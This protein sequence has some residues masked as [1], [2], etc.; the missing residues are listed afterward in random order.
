M[1]TIL[2]VTFIIL[3]LI[4]VPV[5]FALAIACLLALLSDPI[6]TMTI[7]PQ[8]MFNGL[9]SFPLLAIPFFILAGGIMDRGG[10]SEKIINLAN[11]LVGHIRGGLAMITVVASMIFSSMSGSTTAATAA[12]GK[13]VVPA[14]NKR[15]Y[16][17]NFSAGL[18]ASSGALGSIIPP[19]ITLIIFGVVA[20]QSIGQLLVAGIVPGILLGILL[21]I[22]CYIIAL[23][24]KYPS[25]EKSNLKNIG[26]SFLDSILA[27]FMPIIMMGGILLGIFTATEAAVVAILYGLILGMFVYKKLKV[28]DLPEIFYEAILI[29]SMVVLLISIADLFGWLVTSQQ[30]PQ[31]V[32]ETLMS[33]STN[34]Y[35]I[36]ILILI[37]LLIFGLFMESTAAIIIL[38]PVLLPVVL[39]MGM[40]PIHFGLVM[41]VAL[42]IGVVTPPMGVNL[43]VASSITNLS[44]Y[45]VIKGVWP[46]VVVLI[47]GLFI[48]AFMPIL[49]L[50]LPNMMQ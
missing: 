14:M 33:I 18:V 4:N 42:A 31:I 34:P 5:A 37:L 48:L 13:I 11:L 16:S 2:I 44:V 17:K 22:V 46:F 19:S 28:K 40:D 47:I 26:K 30:L 29:S 38:T 25:E 12:I 36:L 3:I 32:A 10:V 24:F 39:G 43:F 21:M 49:T 50:W 9:D 41:I 23:I 1:L 27:L 8:R 45:E 15:G 35:M 7:I 20:G 6:V